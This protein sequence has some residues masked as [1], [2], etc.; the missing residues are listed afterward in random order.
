VDLNLLKKEGNMKN[1]KIFAL[2]FILIVAFAFITSCDEPNENDGKIKVLLTHGSGV[3]VTSQNPVFIN[4]GESATF[5]IKL[6][7]TYVFESVSHGEYND[8]KLTVGGLTRSTSV[9][10]TLKISASIQPR[11]MTFSSS[12]MIMTKRIIPM[13]Q[14]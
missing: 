8:G 7:D 10:F 14:P 11:T 13:P 6:D 5:D 3:T 12:D 1:I 2:L 9:K 4:E